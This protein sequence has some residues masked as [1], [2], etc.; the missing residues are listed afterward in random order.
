MKTYNFYIINDTLTIDK[1]SIWSGLTGTCPT[2]NTSSVYDD[3]KTYCPYTLQPTKSS[4]STTS[5][6]PVGFYPWKSDNHTTIDPFRCYI[7][8]SS[9]SQAKGFRFAFDGGETSGIITIDGGSSSASSASS[10]S[11]SSLI[12]NLQGV[13]VGNDI[14]TLPAGLYVRG[15]KKMVK[16]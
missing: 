15:G 10:S 2:I 4:A 8:G 7:P 13:C 3:T 1:D 9:V 11:S 16:K 5:T 14:N 6:V 12:Y